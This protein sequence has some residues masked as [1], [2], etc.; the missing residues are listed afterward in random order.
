MESFSLEA[1]NPVAKKLYAQ[2]ASKLKI[3]I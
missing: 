3:W 1:D 2:Q